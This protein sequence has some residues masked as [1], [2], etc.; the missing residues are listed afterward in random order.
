MPRVKLEEQTTYEFTF[1]VTLHPRDI[2][3]GGHLG[4][5]SLVTLVGSARAEMFH[6]MGLSEGDL[7]DGKT[8]IIMIDLVMNYRAE[9]FVF[10]KL[11]ISTHVGEMLSSGF[12]IFHRITRDDR[13]IALAEAGVMTFDYTTHRVAHVPQAFIEAVGKA[14]KKPG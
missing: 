3:Y 12:R 10:E 1:Q 13:L 4:N 6:S 5:D 11:D 8:G 2:N 9:A 7:G 14:Q